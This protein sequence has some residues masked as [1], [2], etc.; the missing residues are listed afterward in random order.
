MELYEHNQETYERALSTLEVY[1][2]CAIDQATG[3]GKSFITMKLLDTI[4]ANMSVLYVV[5]TMAIAQSIQD[6]KEWKYD[7]VVFTTYADLRHV[8]QIPDVLV[9]D[10]LHRAGAKTWNTCVMRIKP[11][12]KYSLGLSATPVRYLDGKRDMAAELFGEHVVHGPDVYTAVQKKI[13]PEFDYTVILGDVEKIK[14]DLNSPTTDPTIK[15]KLRKLRLDDY[16]L[17][18]RMRRHISRQHRKAIVFFSTVQELISADIKDWFESNVSIYA[19]HS[20]Q[21][22]SK[23]FKELEAFNRSKCG[24]L[25]VVN[26]V[27]EGLHL[28]GVTLIVFVRRTSSGN[29]FLQQLG[30]ILTAKHTG[31]KPQVIDLVGNYK[32][33][34]TTMCSIPQQR[35]VRTGEAQDTTVLFDKVVVTYDEVALQ[36]MDIYNIVASEWSTVEDDILRLYWK[37]EGRE[38]TKRLNGRSPEQCQSRARVLG[39]CTTNRWSKTEDD[40]LRVFYPMEKTGVINRL[41]GRTLSSITARARKLGLQDVWSRED[42]Y[43]LKE[44]ELTDIPKLLPHHTEEEIRN[45]LREIGRV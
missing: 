30:R 21:S 23:N 27:N 31:T 6:Y 36:V 44:V 34:R 43:I 29:V 4:F 11:L 19:M 20:K 16:D 22:K 24:V 9:L 13:L 14:V 38:V 10:E 15:M 39:L 12:A 33:L 35:T 41:P 2:E 32:N 8:T 42:L 28:D 5:P 37:S 17:T 45:K 3:T 7:N 40:I 25:K 26:I 1:K 18:E